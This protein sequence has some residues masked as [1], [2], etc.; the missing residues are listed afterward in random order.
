M[1]KVPC[2]VGV[3]LLLLVLL[4]ACTIEEDISER[5]QLELS[6]TGII[7]M[8]A[9]PSSRDLTVTTDANEWHAYSMTKWINLEKSAG[10]TLVLQVEENTLPTPRVGSVLVVAG[11]SKRQISVRQ[12][13]GAIRIVTHPDLIKSSRWGGDFTIDVETKTIAWTATSPDE[14]I[15]VNPHP[16]AGRIDVKI[17]PN[18]DR[19]SR[20]GRVLIQGKESGINDT[21]IVVTQDPVDWF[22]MPYMDFA[23]ATR[24][25]IQRFEQSRGGALEFNNDRFLN[26]TT[27]SYAFPRVMYTINDGGAYIHAQ[28]DASS[29]ALLTGDNRKEL[30]DFLRSNGFTIQVD[31]N[32][33]RHEEMTNL[34]VEI[35]PFFKNTPHLL[36]TYKPTQ[37]KAY[38]TFKTL[39]LGFTRFDLGVKS[40]KEYED[41]HG[42]Q[43]SSEAEDELEYTCPPGEYQADGRIYFFHKDKYGAVKL[44]K[45]RQFFYDLTR[46]FW[47]YKGYAQPTDEFLALCKREGF[48]FVEYNILEQVYVFVS[49]EKGLTL[50]IQQKKFFGDPKPVIMIHVNPGDRMIAHN[51]NEDK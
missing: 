45:T 15:R 23:N 20:E 28:V 13:R 33:Y 39:P 19:N 2:K 10:N 11:S 22:V 4:G 31:E 43:L 37:P 17:K 51:Q 49:K 44:E 7:S 34:I 46:A 21:E 30:V 27:T 16:E 8:D 5:S 36:F 6:E 29:S 50:A 26:F 38:D 24:P 48:T 18:N 3:G 42:G 35:K 12:N 47:D 40:V 14:W 25:L 32:T 1:S 41:Q 9:A